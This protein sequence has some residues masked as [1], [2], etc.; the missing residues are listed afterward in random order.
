MVRLKCGKCGKV[1][2]TES[3][4]GVVFG[5]HIGPYKRLTCPACKKRGWFNTWVSVKDP[6]TYGRYG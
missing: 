1:F 3:T 4:M 2:E 5:P 6:V